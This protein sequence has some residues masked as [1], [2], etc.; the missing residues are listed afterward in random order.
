MDLVLHASTN[1]SWATPSI[2]MRRG[3]GGVAHT[4][5]TQSTKI[6]STGWT[7]YDAP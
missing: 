5:S 2:E 4:A 7:A 1:S 3:A 6:L